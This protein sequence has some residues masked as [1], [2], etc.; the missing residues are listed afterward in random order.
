MLDNCN[1]AATMNHHVNICVFSW[2]LVT[3]K[4]VVT[5]RLKTDAL[6]KST[7][8]LLNSQ[9]GELTDKQFRETE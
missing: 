1:F 2:S 4:G 9:T 5:C 7:T 8:I 3:P 6:E